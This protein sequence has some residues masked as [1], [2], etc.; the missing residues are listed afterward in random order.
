MRHSQGLH[1]LAAIEASRR[2][3]FDL[4]VAQPLTA[5]AGDRLD[6]VVVGAAPASSKAPRAWSA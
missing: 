1:R 3:P 2:E 6:G 5:G 4:P